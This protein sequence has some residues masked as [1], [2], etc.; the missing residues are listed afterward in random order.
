MTLWVGDPRNLNL[1]FF[2]IQQRIPLK[3]EGKIILKKG[4]K[5]PKNC[6]TE[7]ES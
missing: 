3:S 6:V 2:Q 1:N 7:Q 5:A 4:Y